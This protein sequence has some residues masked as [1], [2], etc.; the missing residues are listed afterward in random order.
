MKNIVILGASGS[1]GRQAIEII[2]GY[3]DKYNVIGV[4]VHKNTAVLS[5]IL[6]L[7]NPK[8]VVITDVDA[9]ESFV[10]KQSFNCE[11]D[12]GEQA[13]INLAKLP[14]A[15]IILNAIVGF[16]GLKASLSAVRASKILALAN[17]ESLVVAGGILIKEAEKNGAKI[18][19]VDSEHSAIFQC[20]GEQHPHV[21]KII[22]TASGGPFRGYN[23]EQLKSVT[24]EQALKHPNW[25]MGAKITIDSATMMNK[26]LEM[27]EARWLFNVLPPQ[28]EMIVHKQS[29]IHSMVQF[30]DG[31]VLAQL[32]S[33][34]MKLPILYALSYPERFE[35]NI[36][37]VNFAKISTLDFQ[38][39]DR[40]VFKCL[41]LA[42]DAINYGGTLPAIMNAANEA[43]VSLF[44][45]GDIKFY[46]IPR[47]IE[48]AMGNNDASLIFDI[49]SVIELSQSVTRRILKDTNKK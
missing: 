39:P 11:F 16:A 13:A 49:D 15:D 33:P 34:D 5:E 31:A 4:S 42:Y 41:Q 17:K 14:E 47:I 22:L 45:G 12:I 32:G 2:S 44:L 35:T 25:D 3:P 20:L 7:V 36:E 26:G 24:K 9:G 28:I 21:E 29:I 23:R 6:D 1:I 43:A 18:V 27:I 48:E 40:N 8:V 10:K 19:P 30:D 46:Q 37:R 38:V